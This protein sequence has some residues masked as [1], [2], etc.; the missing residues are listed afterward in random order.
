[1]GFSLILPLLPFYAKEMHASP[2]EVTCLFAAYSLGNVFGELYWGRL[3]DRIGRKP[4]LALAMGAAALSY[5]AFAFAPVLR[6][7]L[8][9][10]VVSGFFSG[11]LG[12]VQSYIADI[13]KPEDRA[14]SIGYFMA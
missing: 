7:A 8:V 9:I 10:R 12:V 5:L 13:S 14:R 3:S 1:A 11:T 6:V 4:V 2:F